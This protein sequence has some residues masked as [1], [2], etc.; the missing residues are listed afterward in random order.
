MCFALSVNF[1]YILEKKLILTALKT[2]LKAAA[3][4]V[5]IVGY[6]PK[7]SLSQMTMA[8][9]YELVRVLCVPNRLLFMV[10]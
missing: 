5:G 2:I 4:V 6:D 9:V 7:S 3:G 10:D 1:K 8:K